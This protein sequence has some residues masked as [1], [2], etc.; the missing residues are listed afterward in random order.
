VTVVE[1][2][3]IATT[4]RYKEDD[5]IEE[6]REI[7]YEIGELSV[8]IRATNI[9]GIVVGYSVMDPVKF[10]VY[11]REK[12]KDV[13]WEIRYLLRFLPIE[14]VVLTEISEIKEISIELAKKIP[15][16]DSFKI[17]IEK[18]H[19]NL[20]KINIINE[21]APFILR[22]VNLTN[23]CWTLLIEIIGKYTGIAVINSDL[24]FSSMIEKRSLG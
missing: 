23:P 24:L 6:L 1:F 16:D 10:I 17:L 11:L 13:P 2:N 8:I 9:D 3:F 5:L 7:F 15:I 19:T 18:R 12:L 20:K 22:T 4:F 21:I 14:K